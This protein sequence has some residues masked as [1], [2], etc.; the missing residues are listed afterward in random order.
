MRLGAHVRSGGGVDKSVDRAEELG[1]E[2]IQ[3]FSGAPQAW[4][5]KNYTKEE[6]AAFKARLAETGIGPVFIHGL[7]LMNFASENPDQLKKSYDA[8]VDEMK[9][10]SLIGA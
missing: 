4:R 3:I 1:A 5:R 6:V 7:Y 2:T 10:A 9:A 8:L